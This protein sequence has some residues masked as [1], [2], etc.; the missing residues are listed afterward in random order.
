LNAP[1]WAKVRAIFDELVDLPAP[2]R[3]ARLA[4]FALESPALAKEVEQMLVAD[5]RAGT[6][7]LGAIAGDFA[8]AAVAKAHQELPRA[9]SVGSRFA[10][11]LLVK[12]LGEGGMGSVFLAER[13]GVG[14]TQR[15]AIKLLRVGNQSGEAQRR[16]VAEQRMLAS[17]QHPNVAHLIE[18][19]ISPEGVPYL[20]LEYVD[21]IA[22]TRW[23]D[24]EQL[25]ARERVQLFLHVCAAVEHAHQRLIVHRDLKPS[26]ILVDAAGQ[27]KLLDFGIGKLLS[28][29][30]DDAHLT[31]T[32]MRLFTPGYGAPEQLRGEAISTATD[33]YSLGVVLYELLTGHLP[34]EVAS[35]SVVDWERVVLTAAPTPPSRRATQHR[36][37]EPGEPEWT[38]RLPFPAGWAGDMDAIVLKALRKEP[39]ARYPTVAALREDLCALLEGRPVK[40]RKGS[41]RYRAQKFVARHALAIVLGSTAALALLV[42]TGVALWQAN[43]A[44]VA[45]DRAEGQSLQARLEA[46]R[47]EATVEFLTDVF[48]N[49]DPGHADGAEPTARDLL[50]AGEA[51]LDR[52]TDL[53]AATRTSL[54]IA[55]ARA[56]MGLENREVMLRLM[57]KVQ[58][59]AQASGSA[60]VRIDALLNLGIAYNRNSRRP[61]AL[62]KY[63]EA[64]AVYRE[65]GLVD[66]SVM[67]RIDRLQAI[68][69]SNLDRNAEALVH[70]QRAHAVLLAE[71][72]P[73]SQETADC[74]D[75]YLILLSDLDRG[76][77][78]VA[79]TQPSFAALAGATSVPTQRRAQILASHA[80]ALKLAGRLAEAEAAVRESLKLEESLYGP[81]H[82]AITSTLSKLMSIQRDQGHF[83]EAAATAERTLAIDRAT[84]P[85]GD[86]S[87]LFTIQNAARM[88][89]LA[90]N[91]ARARSLIDEALAGQ[92]ALDAMGTAT[93]AWGRGVNIEILYAEGDLAGARA[94]MQALEPLFPLLDPRNRKH[95]LE[96]RDKLAAAPR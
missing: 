52:A 79:I 40:A 5:A 23:A 16:F 90:G 17:L 62:E 26:N 68:D 59:D 3:A 94:E 83:A 50:V 44:S 29:L 49:A 28:E 8:A 2:L 89:L 20:A 38:P 1:Q 57:E 73:L 71:T 88:A 53:D 31:A 22:L 91:L 19:G 24:R 51:E 74:L 87:L 70:I 66:A 36:S 48:A 42:G 45:R 18:G 55:M 35:G 80:Y 93:A 78:G 61:E 6:Q 86:S 60:R 14:Y 12:V 81:D 92:R 37:G 84:L 34:F 56:H 69:L 58:A 4:D 41:R 32:G 15:A 75:V 95:I 13:D 64:E 39:D 47:A 63:R 46:R 96:L 33:V 43:E 82:Q 25:P 54:T 10:S 7:Q 9:L 27:V 21:G 67:A 65:S 30:D 11:W 77:E 85:A 72:G 76:R